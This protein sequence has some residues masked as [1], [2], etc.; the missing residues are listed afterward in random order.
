MADLNEYCFY[1]K[2]RFEPEKNAAKSSVILKVT[3]G[4]TVFVQVLR[5]V[6]CLGVNFWLKTKRLSMPLLQSRFNAEWFVSFSQI[7]MTLNGKKIFNYIA[8]SEAK[9]CD[10][11]RNFGQRAR[12][13]L[14]RSV[15]WSFVSL[16]KVPGRLFGRRILLTRQMLFWRNK[17]NPENIWPHQVVI[18]VALRTILKESVQNAVCLI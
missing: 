15:T 2:F 17:F 13:V 16:Y 18:P 12:H 11:L 6:L 4:S 7:K 9:S 10:N 5:N 8:T 1:I 3:L 14:L